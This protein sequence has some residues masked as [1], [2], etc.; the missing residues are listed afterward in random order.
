VADEKAKKPVDTTEYKTARI[1][2]PKIDAD[3]S[4]PAAEIA[5]ALLRQFFLPQQDAVSR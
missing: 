5:E 4:R 1:S 3:F 2:I